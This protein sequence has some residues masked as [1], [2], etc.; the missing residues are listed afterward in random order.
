MV[1][2]SLLMRVYTTIGLPQNKIFAKLRIQKVFN[3]V[4]IQ[5]EYLL[6]CGGANTDRVQKTHQFLAGFEKSI[7]SHIIH[8]GKRKITVKT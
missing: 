2:Y 6:C 4:N 3:E 8:R 5:E 7:S 1:F